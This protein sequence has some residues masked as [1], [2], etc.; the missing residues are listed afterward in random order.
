MRSTER[1]HR[2]TIFWAKVAAF[3]A[4]LAI[5]VTIWLAGTGGSDLSTGA[6]T[7][8]HPA[9][10]RVSLELRNFAT[11]AEQDATGELRYTEATQPRVFIN[12]RNDGGTGTAVDRV[13]LIADGQ[14]E[15][16]YC[17]PRGG[18]AIASW[19]TG[20]LIPRSPEQGAML[21]TDDPV[22]YNIDADDAGRI[23]LRLRPSNEL[24]DDFKTQHLF[25]FRVRIRQVSN[26]R[27]LEAGALSSC[28]QAYGHRIST[29]RVHRP[30]TRF[31]GPARPLIERA[32]DSSHR[33]PS[34]PT[35]CGRSFSTTT[36]TRPGRMI[37]G[38]IA[39]RARR[40]RGRG[41]EGLL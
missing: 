12:L 13:E 24:L 41:H 21:T 17:D 10:L 25:R 28:S 39:E 31:T 22:A 29:T 6:T 26:A 35:N 40:H 5:P 32:F 34:S 20:V 8:A 3:A 36:A 30:M 2:E 33:E 9:K 37:L 15:L 14:S 38:R 4:V 23:E 27:W 11:H 1:R 7:P 16:H 18:E 19:T